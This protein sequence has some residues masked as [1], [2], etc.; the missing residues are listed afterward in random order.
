MRPKPA[1]HAEEPLT[2]GHDLAPRETPGAYPLTEA[3][4]VLSEIARVSRQ[5]AD[6]SGRISQGGDRSILDDLKNGAPR[7]RSSF[8]PSTP[9]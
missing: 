6:P 9:N 2:F 4:S 8:D 5:P 1:A 7:R 3:I